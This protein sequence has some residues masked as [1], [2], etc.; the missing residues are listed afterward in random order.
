MTKPC[1]TFHV[2]RIAEQEITVCHAH[3]SLATGVLRGADRFDYAAQAGNLQ[4][5]FQD[6]RER[7]GQRLG[8]RNGQV[9]DC[10]VR[11]RLSGL[12]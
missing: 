9:V 4:T 5:F 7:Q 2:M 8:A 3:L 6:Q 1:S 11:R 12:P 10:A